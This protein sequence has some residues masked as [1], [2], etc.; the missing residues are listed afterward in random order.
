MHRD[1]LPAPDIGYAFVPRTGRV[2][3]PSNPARPC[4]TTHCARWRC[5]NCW[6]LS[7]PATTPR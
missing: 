2:A 1:T 7:R 6:R 3:M 5:R 4:A